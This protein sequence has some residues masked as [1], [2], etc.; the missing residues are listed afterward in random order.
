MPIIH[1]SLKDQMLWSNPHFQTIWPTI[2]FKTPKDQRKA[3][4]I[5][6]KDGDEIYLDILD[7]ESPAISGVLLLHGLTGSSDSRYIIQLQ[8]TLSQQKIL[9]V[10]M[11]YRGAKKPNYLAATYHA[12]KTDD[13]DRTIEY[14]VKN[15]PI[16]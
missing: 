11:N 13:L 16:H 2:C 7:A 10:A 9:S 12:G 1:T 4:F 5:E 14:L 6:T 15:L 3:V 8:E